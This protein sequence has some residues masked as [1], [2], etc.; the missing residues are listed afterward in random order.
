MRTSALDD[1]LE[2]KP[3]GLLVNVGTNDQTNNVNLLNSVKTM[4]KKVKNSSSNT[5]IVFSSVI[6]CKC[7]K[8][9]SKEVGETKQRLKNYSKQKNIHFG[10]NSNIIEEHLRGKKLH[11]DKRGNSILANNILSYVRDS[12]WIDDI[13]I[14]GMKYDECKSKVPSE[15][16]NSMSVRSIW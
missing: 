1:L 3:D 16:L 2:V 13:L 14:C 9:I 6:L 15:S 7:K 10:D 11:L 5:N 8:D 12:Y 4:V